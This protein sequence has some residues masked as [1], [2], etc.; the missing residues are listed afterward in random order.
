MLGTPRRW[1]QRDALWYLGDQAWSRRAVRDPG[2]LAGADGGPAGVFPCGK[3]CGW[4]VAISLRMGKVDL[5]GKPRLPNSDSLRH[6]D[7]VWMV[8]PISG[9]VSGVDTTK[10]PLESLS[11]LPPAIRF[12]FF[13]RRSL[14]ASIVLQKG[15]ENAAVPA[16]E[17]GASGKAR[18]RGSLFPV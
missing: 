5:P 7:Q 15:R 18:P 17:P 1:W 11:G 8:L 12:S 9:G 2:A 14:F 6:G 4:R 10:I 16:Q 13:L 3:R